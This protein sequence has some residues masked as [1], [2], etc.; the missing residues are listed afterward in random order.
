MFAIT[1]RLAFNRLP[2]CPICC[3]E[4]PPDGLATYSRIVLCPTCL[5]ATP[6]HALQDA[7]HHALFD[8][9]RSNWNDQLGFLFWTPPSEHPHVAPAHLTETPTQPLAC[10]WLSPFLS[11]L[12]ARRQSRPSILSNRQL[13]DLKQ[14]SCA[15]RV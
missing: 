8:R 3:N 13:H 2:R 10:E 9:S 11:E 6:E 4:L 7:L 14:T 12:N 5:N 1:I 15:R